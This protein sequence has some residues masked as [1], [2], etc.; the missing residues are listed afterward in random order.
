MLLPIDGKIAPVRVRAAPL[1]NKDRNKV[2]AVVEASEFIR[3]D[4]WREG[5]PADARFH[6]VIETA[7]AMTWHEKDSHDCPSIAVY[8]RLKGNEDFYLFDVALKEHSKLPVALILRRSELAEEYDFSGHDQESIILADAKNGRH[9]QHLR[10]LQRI[11]DGE[12]SLLVDILCENAM[13]KPMELFTEDL[14]P[15][16]K[17]LAANFS[18]A[19]AAREQRWAS[20]GQSQIQEFLARTTEG[21]QSLEPSV[22]IARAVDC[23]KNGMSREG[24][25]MQDLFSIHVRLWDRNRNA[26]VLTEHGFGICQQTHPPERALDYE[27]ESKNSAYAASHHEAIWVDRVEFDTLRKEL[28]REPDE[29]ETR[30]LKRL[31]GYCTLPLFAASRLL[32]TLNVQFCD[33][34]ALSPGRRN[35]LTAIASAL[36][37]SLGWAKGATYYRTWMDHFNMLDTMMLGQ[38]QPG[39][40][41][42]SDMAFYQSITKMVFDLTSAASVLYYQRDRSTGVLH[43]AADTTPSPLKARLHFPA[44][45]PK[46]LG[47]VGAA[48]RD[49]LTHFVQDYADPKWKS[50]RDELLAAFPAGA[51]KETCSWIRSEIAVP[52][53]VNGVVDGL[54]VAVSPIPVW[55]SGDDEETMKQIAGKVSK[56]LVARRAGYDLSMQHLA[57]ESLSK[58]TDRMGRTVDRS[59]LQRLLLLGVTSGDCLGFSRAIFFE[60]SADAKFLTPEMAV[61]AHSPD[62]ARSRWAEARLIP[63]DNQIQ[64]CLKGPAPVREGDLLPALS[65]LNLRLDFEPALKNALKNF[66]PVERRAADLHPIR[67]QEFLGRITNGVEPNVEYVLWPMYAGEQ[68]LGMVWADRAFHDQ[69][70]IDSATLKLLGLLCAESTWMIR[71]NEQRQRLK[72][73]AEQNLRI[74]KGVSYSLRTRAGALEANVALLKKDLGE[75]HREAILGMEKAVR[76][77]KHA[78]TLAAKHVRLRETKG[79]S[80]EAPPI[81]IRPVVEETA[82]QFGDPR[83]TL[84]LGDE[85][86]VVAIDRQQLQDLLLELLL[87]ARDFTDAT[88]GRI[89]VTCMAKEDRVVVEIADNGPGIHPEL[90]PRL[91][92]MFKP[93]PVT[94]MG[95]GLAYARALAQANGGDIHETGTFGRGACFRI[96]LPARKETYHARNT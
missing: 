43:L 50:V 96:E 41:K 18:Q 83:I 16:W 11:T 73:E 49:Q 25:A 60:L 88:S 68:A 15:Y 71:S 33:D 78:G 89:V 8:Y 5:S 94:R 46:D 4:E 66:E 52:V 7:R 63:F 57:I 24:Q 80:L 27:V 28:G 6:R 59:A 42:A 77:F 76:F 40:P 9:Y 54:L 64:A 19:L 61:G 75:S 67:D 85:A 39:T 72:V 29:A 13:P 10:L 82:S 45:M 22:I 81:D 69:P 65:G 62:H 37:S 3:E 21:G 30:A 35:F 53:T 36:S 44:T 2:L 1:L 26:L 70:T 55:L 31:T 47:I 91:F 84:W 95:M 79:T 58:I 14:A 90:R 48:V 23:I 20:Q 86:L 93:S 51:E 34:S 38:D 17:Y 32:G 92:Q 12:T 87:N 56:S 74:A